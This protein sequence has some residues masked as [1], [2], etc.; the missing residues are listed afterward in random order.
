MKN[1]NWDDSFVSVACPQPVLWVGGG[2]L[3]Q[4]KLATQPSFRT[5][6][7]HARKAHYRFPGGNVKVK[8]SL[9]QAVEAF[10]VVR[11]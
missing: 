11:C 10:R 6:N 2:D 8:L 7:I 4:A 5:P 1:G 9:K 3:R